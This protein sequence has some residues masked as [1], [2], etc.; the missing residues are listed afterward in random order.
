[1]KCCAV[2]AIDRAVDIYGMIAAHWYN[3]PPQHS[4]PSS[5]YLM[6]YLG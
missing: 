3:L 6:E 2:A 5:E 1:M 4:S